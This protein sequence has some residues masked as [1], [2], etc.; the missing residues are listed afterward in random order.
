MSELDP[1]TGK[2]EPS[3]FSMKF[4]QFVS[5]ERK[6]P[7]GKEKNLPQYCNTSKRKGNWVK[8]DSLRLKRNQMSTTG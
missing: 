6:A 7:K 4:G 3:V 5:G 8:A 1:S 2:A